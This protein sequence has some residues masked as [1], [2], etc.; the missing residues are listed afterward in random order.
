MFENLVCNGEK[1]AAR[2]CNS[3]NIW[4]HL[5]NHHDDEWVSIPAS[6]KKPFPCI[7]LSL[8]VLLFITT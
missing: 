5:K 3:K 8:S 7:S 1:E 6:L 2:V 4:H